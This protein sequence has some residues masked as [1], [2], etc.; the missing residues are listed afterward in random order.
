VESSDELSHAEQGATALGHLTRAVSHLVDEILAGEQL[1]VV[2]GEDLQ[3]LVST[4]I[5]LYGGVI[6]LV[7]D[8]V[9]PLD[10]DV[11]QAE[12]MALA[13]ALLKSL[14]LDPHDLSAWLAENNGRH[15]PGRILVG[16]GP[17]TRCPGVSMAWLEHSV[18][19]VF[20]ES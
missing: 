8:D 3:L 10:G 2:D 14:R 4:A 6:S 9:D 7:P 15:D 19:T 18:A 5:R 12:A 17:R 11:T 16:D 20:D 1:Q 13:S